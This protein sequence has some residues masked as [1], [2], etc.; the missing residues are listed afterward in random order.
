MQP[1]GVAP[2]H[3]GLVRD[4][5]AQASPANQSE[6]AARAHSRTELRI[7]RLLGRGRRLLDERIAALRLAFDAERGR[8]DVIDSARDL[9]K[10]DRVAVL[11]LEFNFR[12]RA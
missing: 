12:N 11:E 8:Y 3:R 1:L 2:Y 7:V 10:L 4:Q 5:M 6:S 9:K